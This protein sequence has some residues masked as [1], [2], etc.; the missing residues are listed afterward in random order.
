MA[1]VGTMLCTI[2]SAVRALAISVETAAAQANGNRTRA[3]C[4]GMAAGASHRPAHH[5]DTLHAELAV[6]FGVERVVVLGES[7]DMAV[8]DQVQDI[9]PPPDRIHIPKGAPYLLRS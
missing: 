5:G 6:I 2:S 8:E 1:R 9:R 4:K 7:R 3:Q